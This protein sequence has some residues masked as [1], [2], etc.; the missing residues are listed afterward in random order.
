MIAV[1]VIAF[2]VGVI[3]G[4]LCTFAWFVRQDID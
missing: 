1:V 3:L 4:S 2:Y